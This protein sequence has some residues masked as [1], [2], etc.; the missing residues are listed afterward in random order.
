MSII[1]RERLKR[2]FD[3][4]QVSVND[5]QDLALAE[6]ESYDALKNDENYRAAYLK[7][8]EQL[9]EAIASNTDGSIAF[10]LRLNPDFAGPSGGF[11]WGRE[12]N[13]WEGTAASFYRRN[14]IDLSKYSPDDTENV[15]WYYIPVSRGNATWIEPYVDPIV[16]VYVIS[17]VSP[18]YIDGNFIGVVGMDIDF[19]YL[20]HEVRRMS[21]YNYGYAYLTDRTGH[22]LYHQRFSQGELFQPSEDF[23][24]ME[25]YLTNG[26][27]LGI[28]MPKYR[29]YA[30]RNS[31]LMH[32]ISVML[33][34][35]ILV[36]FLSV[37]LASRGIRPLIALT[38]A[39][40]KI[41]EGNL[42]VELPGESK[43]ELGVLVRSIREMVSKL[44]IYVYRDK[45]TGV[46]NTTAYA[47]KCEELA[48]SENY[49]IVVFDLNFLKKTND[50]YGHEAGNLLIRGTADLI[51]KI[52]V[53]DS[54]FRIGGD[55]FVAILE[56]DDFKC[57]DE[58]IAAF[59]KELA[60]KI[61][62]V[63][64]KEIP[65]SIARGVGIWREGSD[66]AKIF[67]EADEAMYANKVEIKK[68]FGYKAER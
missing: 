19:D 2:T 64:D 12:K 59:D 43:N 32:L 47:R 5:I 36:S 66:Y 52:F 26:I 61:F 31:L 1:C 39:A 20:I 17:Y 7:K 35:A 41:A 10:Y 22:V 28:A 49:A 14:P 25:T 57:R 4:I 16:Q 3:G 27:W 58:L 55:E 34:V 53:N 51:E 18:L 65:L 9:F 45:L 42:N 6:L 48:N 11:S 44:E 54:V 50:T 29:I 56:G 24:E 62:T 23:R 60:G 37:Y 68:A 8:T 21:V 15:G 38:E 40:Q 33:A 67:R 63:K 46:R 30:D 13:R